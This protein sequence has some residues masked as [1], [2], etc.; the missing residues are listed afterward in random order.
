MPNGLFFNAIGIPDSPTNH[1]NTRQMDAI[2]FSNVLVLCY[3]TLCLVKAHI[4]HNLWTNYLN[5]NYLKSEL[6]KVWYSDPL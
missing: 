6:Q 3:E 5:T 2:L 1:L 4:G